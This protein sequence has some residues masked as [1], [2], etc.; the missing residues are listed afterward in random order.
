[1]A[2]QD[3]LFWATGIDNSGLSADKEKALQIFKQLSSGFMAELQKMENQYAQ[4][5]EKSNFKFPNP[6]E[7]GTFESVRK[8]IADVGKVIDSE[9]GKL[10]NLSYQYDKAMSKI[11]IS[12]SKIP[13]VPESS[14]L[15]PTIRNIHNSVQQADS[16]ISYLGRIFKRGVSYMLIYGSIDWAK[17]FAVNVVKTKGEFD[18]LR[19]GIDAFVN[20]A[21]KSK[22]LFNDITSFAVRSPFQLLDIT[23]SSKE[24]LSY[25]V[26][27]KNVMGTLKMLSNIASGSGQRIEDLTYLYGT[28]MTRGRVYRRE[29]YQ[30]ATRGIPIYQALSK[31]LGVNNEQLLKMVTSGR[32]GFSQLERALQSMSAAGGIYYGISDKI[33][34]TT[35]GRLSNLEDKWKVALDQIGDANEGIMNSGIE[36]TSSLIGNWQKVADT[37]KEVIV[38]AGA[39]KASQIAVSAMNKGSEVAYAGAYTKS[40]V[41]TVSP[42]WKEQ[43]SKAGLIEGSVAYQREL[44]KELALELRKS[45][46]AIAGAEAEITRN[47]ELIAEKEILIADSK[48]N[49][50]AKELEVDA[51]V[52]NGS[53]TE[54]AT[55]QVSLNSAQK[56]LNTLETDKNTAAESLNKA[57]LELS[58]AKQTENTLATT[59]NTAV[60]EGNTAAKGAGAIATGVLGNA[61]MKLTNFM[62]ANKFAL[63]TAAIAGVIYVLYKCSQAADDA[64]KAQQEYDKTINKIKD[65]QQKQ[66]SAAGDLLNIME[67]ETSPINMKQNALSQ[68]QKLM[69]QVF[70]NMKLETALNKDGLYWQ[71]KVAEQTL[72]NANIQTRIA[73]FQAQRQV[74][75]TKNNLDNIK[76]ANEG[77]G[78]SSDPLADIINENNAQSKYDIA[79]KYAQSLSKLVIEINSNLRNAAI[80]KASVPKNEDYWKEQVSYWQ[81]QRAEMPSSS[82]GSTEWNHDIEMERQAQNELDK[83]E[84]SSQIDKKA[85][86]AQ[87]KTE[88]EREQKNAFDSE[89][90]TRKEQIRS[91]NK[92]IT[93]Y[94]AQAEQMRQEA[95]ADDMDKGYMHDKLVIENEY[96]KKIN[97]IDNEKD[98]ILKL[99]QQN[100]KSEYLNIPVRQRGKYNPK[101]QTW[102]D[103]PESSKVGV[104]DAIQA[105]NDVRLAKEHQLQN[106]L[107]ISYNDYT[108]QKQEIDR[109]Y[110]ADK[111]A[112]EDI[113][114]QYKEGSSEYGRMTLRIA[115]NEKERVL[116]QSNLSF[117]QVKETPTYQLAFD[118]L[119]KV[120]TQGLWNLMDMLKEYRKVAVEAYNPEDIK[121]YTEEINKVFDKLSKKDPFTVMSKGNKDLI[122]AKKE[123]K[124]SE[125][126]L[127]KAKK[128]YDDILAESVTTPT[129]SYTSEEIST[130]KIKGTT[131]FTS[132]KNESTTNTDK[133]TAAYNKLTAAQNKYVISGSK[134][135][136]ITNNIKT[137]ENTLTTSLGEM[138]KSITSVG[139]SIGGVTGGIVS[140]VG[141]IATT[142]STAITG[143]HA[144]A[145]MGADAIG[146]IE[147]A[148]VI[149]AVISTAIQLAEKVASLFSKESSFQKLEKELTS[150]NKTLEGTIS[151][152]KDLLSK[153]AGSASLTT[154][155]AEIA[156][157]KEEVA[158]YQALAKAKMEDSGTGHHSIKHNYGDV[159]TA[160]TTLSLGLEITQNQQDLLAFNSTLQDTYGISISNI[161]D[162]SSLTGEQLETLKTKDPEAWSRLNSTVTGYF[163]EIISDANSLQDT[164]NEIYAS[165][166]GVDWSDLKDGLDDLLLSA[167]TTMS[168][169]SDNF[170]TDMRKAILNL[171]KSNYLTSALQTWYTE[172]A[173]DLNDNTLSADEAAK[174]KDEYENVYTTASDKIDALLALADVSKTDTSSNT[175]KSS[176]QSMS[177][178]QADVLSAQFSA[179]RLNVSDILISLK[180]N[181][182][183]IDLIASDISA[184]KGYTAFIGDIKSIVSDMY[185]KGV[186]VR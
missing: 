61:W 58:S 123:L 16:D 90:K 46:I 136:G 53:A 28:S 59:M 35:Y 157:I 141:S 7:A 179:I 150:L 149:L 55:A 177:E 148:S 118:D 124:D 17:N 180:D 5:K 4:L 15:A 163:D 34:L 43:A 162:L 122:K 87:T 129:L 133:T 176:F 9:I 151:L 79:L 64:T 41:S 70:A 73:Y 80:A 42:E 146:T 27:A 92:E 160:E 83:Y 60:E 126:E 116:A 108:Q 88:R 155:A 144:A 168:D 101:I 105:A 31:E 85:K 89:V 181:N 183:K 110:Y 54:V 82:A 156:S 6:V 165:A 172:F 140:L 12:A 154:G 121:T 132:A 166:T 174:L 102:N 139:D 39:Y 36:M 22:E 32:V 153:E 26:N 33:A 167:D 68:L 75:S 81:Q 109:K 45:S 23:K 44:E 100:E 63:I 8:Q 99:S 62:K 113:R 72:Y 25:G 170:E 94:E 107:L 10:S 117:K 106:E 66:T 77:G 164:L 127:V 171:V 65:D 30:F 67:Q 161:E 158:N 21:K 19:A 185:S 74:M 1:M 143:M 111:Q 130:P 18:Q 173:G 40:A 50:A 76:K 37:I 47:T 20:N 97:D 134:V 128:E 120:S 137:A 119:N 175:V 57:Q 13:T 84:K 178:D 11:K 131:T 145:E 86:S 115:Q 51:A 112:L 147:K 91:N 29:L 78:T 71:K 104:N 125:D 159:S 93:D 38:V 14:P 169:I 138:G 48:K 152:Y 96:K 135:Q 52:A 95:Y 184:I 103:V 186:I 3:E 24:L 98:K 114:S 49:V 182:N 56:E 142:V 69:P 2:S